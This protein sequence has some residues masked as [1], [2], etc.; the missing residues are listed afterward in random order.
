MGEKISRTERQLNLVSSLFRARDGLNWEDILCIHGYD[1]TN[2]EQRSRQRRFERD[3]AEL[4][5]TG[6]IVRRESEAGERATYLLDRSACLLPSLNLTHEQRMLL[7]RMGL[8]YMED[9]GAGSLSEP[10]STALMKLQAGAGGDGLPDKLP[11]GFVR[12]SLNRRPSDGPHM[13]V[14]GPALLQRRRLKF[15][16]DKRG[17]ESGERHVAPYALVSRWGGW[18]LVGYDIG[19]KA[20]RVFRLSRI[21]GA[22]ALLTPRQKAPEYDVPTDFDPERHFAA[23]VFGKGRDGFA[24]VRIR[25]D[26]Q[27]AFI[28][29]NE[30]EGLYR[31]EPAAGGAIVLHLPCAYPMELFRY[32]CEFPGY[33]EVLSPQPLRELVE[34]ELKAGLAQLE[35]PGGRS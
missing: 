33:W 11:R 24:D 2:C 4:R 19:R 30:F 14:I 15:R 7:L 21:Q 17:G 9:G 26:V 32:L 31:I 29:E 16:Y 27:V 34:R 22:I 25:F 28:V 23:D 20:E 5:E 10:L 1:D 8:G 35:A 13:E 18:Y 3:L 12:R 6:L